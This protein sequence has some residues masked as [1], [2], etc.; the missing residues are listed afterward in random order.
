MQEYQCR[1]IV[2]LSYRLLLCAPLIWNKLLM[3]RQRGLMHA[4]VNPQRRLRSV[5]I[6]NKSVKGTKVIVMA[7]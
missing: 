6:I 1:K 2:A 7:V 5:K 3:R 4:V